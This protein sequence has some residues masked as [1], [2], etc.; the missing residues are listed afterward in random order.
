MSKYFLFIFP[1]L[2]QIIITNIIVI[3]EQRHGGTNGDTNGDTSDDTSGDTL[4]LALALYSS[5]KLVLSKTAHLSG[6]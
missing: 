3:I 5:L 1:K 6:S 2:T 4:A